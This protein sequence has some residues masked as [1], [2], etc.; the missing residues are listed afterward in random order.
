MQVRL[1]VV[2]S[3]SGDG[4]GPERQDERD[5]D[6][7]QAAQ[8]LVQ[9]RVHAAEQGAESH[10]RRVLPEARRPHRPRLPERRPHQLHLRVLRLPPGRHRARANRGAAHAPR[11]RITADRIPARQLRHSGV[12]MK[13]NFSMPKLLMDRRILKFGSMYYSFYCESR[14]FICNDKFICKYIIL[15]FCYL[16]LPHG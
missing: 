4:P 2:Q 11:R 16:K 1:G 3:A 5:A 14:Q 7:R 9:D 12:W 13:W 8:P 15:L 10:R 6:L